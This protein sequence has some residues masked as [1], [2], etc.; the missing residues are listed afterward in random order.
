ML[1]DIPRSI[2]N[3]TSHTIEKRPDGSPT[4]YDSDWPGSRIWPVFTPE[5]E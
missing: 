5:T 1:P 4:V 2:W 3:G